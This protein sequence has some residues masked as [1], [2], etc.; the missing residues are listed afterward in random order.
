MS[1]RLATLN[2][3]LHELKIKILFNE[4][5]DKQREYS[6]CWYWFITNDHNLSIIKNSGRFTDEYIN[7][8]ISLPILQM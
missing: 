6:I 3:I 5:N 1:L 7:K 4:N 2:D 8:I